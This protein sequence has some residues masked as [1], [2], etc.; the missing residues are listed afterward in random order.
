MSKIDFAQFARNIAT[1][2]SSTNMLPVIEKEL[3]HYEILRAMQ[4][5][6]LL[7][8]LSFQGGTCLRLCYSAQRA[9]EDLDF[10]GGV[11]FEASRLASL[12]DCIEQALPARYQVQ[13]Q[14]SDAK[15]DDSLL[16][17]W[18]VRIDTS[19]LRPD[20]PSQKITLEVAAIPAYT[21]EPRMLQLNYKGLPSSYEDVVVPCE[22][23]EEILADKLESFI[24]SPRIRYR[25]IWDL[26][27]L[28]R[29]PG[30]DKDVAHALRAKKELDYN[31]IN[32]F[33]KGIF[34]VADQ[35]DE[36]IE[37]REFLMQMQRFLPQDIIANTVERKDWRIAARN[38]IANLYERYL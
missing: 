8:G 22:S 2:N 13:V 16:K 6:R 11:A 9:S 1:A 20:L 14:V 21:N 19:P 29:R 3:L 27:W 15:S 5:S 18:R 12:K 36:I 34:R 24:C 10:A 38:T 33:A 17:K 28:A 25:D 4:E 31:E 30:L 32:T 23:L 37:G 26:Q 7:A 35:L